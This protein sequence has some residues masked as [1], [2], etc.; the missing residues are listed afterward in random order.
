MQLITINRILYI[1]ADKR[2]CSFKSF[3]SLAM[4]SGYIVSSGV[5]ILRFFNIQRNWHVLYLAQNN[6]P[7]WHNTTEYLILVSSIK[8]LLNFSSTSFKAKSFIVIYIYCMYT[9]ND[10]YVI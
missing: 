9:T 7:K 10:D 2:K 3:F 5:Y 4:Q 1:K 8:I 6:T